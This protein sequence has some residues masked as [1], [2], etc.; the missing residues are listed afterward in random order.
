[1]VNRVLFWEGTRP[2]AYCRRWTITVQ[3][4]GMSGRLTPVPTL[5]HNPSPTTGRTWECHHDH[6]R[7]YE[8]QSRNLTILPVTLLTCSTHRIK[9][10]RARQH[11]GLCGWARLCW[12]DVPVKMCSLRVLKKNPFFFIRK[13]QKHVQ[14]VTPTGSNRYP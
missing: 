12:P 14:A 10:M 3:T 9:R 8:H 6:G 7:F 5:V 1:M 4:R 2:P 11:E 13:T